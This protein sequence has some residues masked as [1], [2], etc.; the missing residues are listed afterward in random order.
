MSDRI[1]LP[2]APAAL[3]EHLLDGGAIAWSQPVTITTYETGEPDAY[4]MFFDRRVYQGSSG[5]VYPIPFVDRIDADAAPREWHAL[6]LENRW[7]RLMVLPELGGR[8]HVGFDKVA[9]YDF[10]YR[11]NVI[12]PALVGLGGPWISGGVEFNW[13]HHH[14]P[15]TYLPVDVELEQGDDGSVTV[16]CSDHDP[17]ARMKGMHGIRLHPERAVVELIGRVHNRTSEPQTFLWW[18]NVAAAVHDEYQSFFPTDVRYV[19]DHARRAIT[20]FPAADRPY[21]GVDYP[22]RVAGGGDRL[23]WF[24]NIPVPTSYMVTDTVDDFFGGYDHRA[25]AGF[26]HVAD[27]H[28]APGKKQWTWGDAAFGQ[29]WDRL[30]TDTDGPYIE[31]M[32]G[33]YTDNQ[34]DFAWLQPGETKTF[35]QSWF[36]IQ[37]IGP[38]QQANEDAAVALALDAGIAHVGICVTADRPGATV[39]VMMGQATALEQT[40]DLAP[41]KPLL[42]NVPVGDVD[43]MEVEVTV[44][45][46]GSD[47]IRWRPRSPS[48]ALEPWTATEPPVPE[49]IESVEELYLTGLHLQQYR[50]PTWSPLP[51]WTEALR[52]DPADARTNLAL[53]EHHHR[54]GEYATAVEHARTALDRLTTRNANPRDGEASYRLGLALLR[55][56]RPEAAR[57]ALAKAAWD[58]RWTGPAVLELARLDAQAGRWAAALDRLDSA[59]PGDSRAETVRVVAMRALGRERDAVDSLAGWLRRDPL[60]QTAR[61][62]G[63]RAASTDGRTLIDVALELRDAGD[64]AGA[65]AVLDRATVA[66]ATS[67]GNVAPM[68]WYHRALITDESTDRVRAHTAP[69]DRCFP[70]GLDD[71]DALV[72]AL[73]ANP[74]DARAAA[75]LGM[76]L[77]D[78]GR[79]HDALEYFERAIALGLPDPV[80]LRNAALTGFNITGDGALARARYDAA[81]ELDR[82]ARLLHE[83]DQLLARLDATPGERLALLDPEMSEVLRRDD[84]TVSYCRLLAEAGRAAEARGILESRPFA[85]W[86]GGEGQA[87]SAWEVVTATLSLE[88]QVRGDLEVAADFARRAIELPANLGEVRHPLT[89]TTALHERLASLLERL[90]Q[91]DAAADARASAVFSAVKPTAATLGDAVDYFATSLP[92]LLL[93]GQRGR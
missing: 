27:R 84:L 13:P 42:V 48:P 36:P 47:L 34:P 6:H 80:L 60:D 16:W 52:R 59:T 29:A 26:V 37:K 75:L 67:A 35:T 50:H 22:A 58:G 91:Q 79:Q 86:E 4:P 33:V 77:L 78:A 57:D 74:N 1:V 12:K 68:A 18:A 90:G 30:L 40:I 82:T 56:G 9:Q 87:I 24:R 25:G 38:V 8:I 41:G 23:D 81:L 72:A 69:A 66:Q 73:R 43:P 21:Y 45:Q 17:F 92:D 14:R 5:K 10:F 62:L 44:S 88:A 11:N 15:A 3:A 61:I 89:D 76:L 65:L 32:A 64:R 55:L 83:R 93:F 46:G 49:A 51:Y 70:A 28:V 19:A 54:R 53:A 39:R 20:A 71:H 7:I 85:P 31:L 2:D 63:R